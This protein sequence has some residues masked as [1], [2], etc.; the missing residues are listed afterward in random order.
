[1]TVARNLALEAELVRIA[2]AFADADVDLVVLKGVPQARRLYG[3]LAARRITDN[4]LL[5][6]R[7]QAAS[8]HAVLRSIGYAGSPFLEFS[9]VVHYAYE[10]ALTCALPGGH[11][12]VADLHWAPWSPRLHPIPEELVWVRTEPFGL[13][14]GAVVRVLDPVMTILN[15]A[16]HFTQHHFAE[17]QTVRDLAAAW[18]AWSEQI[19]MAELV[20]L[21]RKADLV[22]ALVY[23]FAVA[24]SSGLIAGR[25]QLPNSLRGWILERMWPRGRRTR[26]PDFFGATMTLVM[27][28]PRGFFRAARATVFP[29][30]EVLSNATK[31]PWSGRMYRLY[32]TRPFRPLVPRRWRRD[33]PASLATADPC[34]PVDDVRGRAG[35]APRQI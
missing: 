20:A 29:R 11:M 24:E 28:R 19:D 32:L 25:P 17:D 4:D 18:R 2:R 26:R 27:S 1:M 35:E 34:A 3:A 5:V 13:G 10:T 9:N 14:S 23:V 15:A 16:A 12:A 7:N 22:P 8:A 31:R 33:R 6:R 30:R 21:A